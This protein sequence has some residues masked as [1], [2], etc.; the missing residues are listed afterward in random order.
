MRRGLALGGALLLLG[1]LVG[2]QGLNRS[3]T[4]EGLQGRIAWPKDGDL[5]VIDLSSKQQRKITQ[6]GQGA[7]V[8]GASWS[9]DGKRV[10]YAQFWRRPNER[11][12]G[13]DLFVANPDGSDAR[14]FAERDAPSTVYDGP[15]WAAS[16]RVYYTVRKV[17]NG[18]EAQSIVRQT[19]G[20]TPE[21]VVDNGYSPAV[22]PDES[23]LIYVRTT[24]LAQALWKKTIG[25]PGEGCE[26]LS[27]QVFLAL[28]GA[29]FSPDGTRLALGGSGEP[30]PQP[31]PSGC[32]GDNRATPGAAGPPSSPGLDLLAWLSPGA[33][34][35]EAASAQHGQPWDIW[36]LGLDGS[37]L[38]K[39]ADLKDDEP[40]VAWSPDGSRLAIFGGL[41]GLNLVDGRGGQPQKLVDQGGY[42]GLDWTR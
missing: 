28:N 19:E 40:T 5:W 41:G 3:A 21:L 2:C 39:L 13:S 36:S 33:S 24:R 15:V 17:Q 22:S 10:V 26:L 34:V 8:T 1:L 18:R 9:P 30:S 42:G 31:P 12:S 14:P 38:T 32:G 35:A 23:T 11:V 20:G 25:Q 4:T 37:G 29:R 27:D 6:L 16:G 7:V